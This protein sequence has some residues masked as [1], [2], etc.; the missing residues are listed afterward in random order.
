M[1]ARAL[2]AR[3]KFSLCLHAAIDVDGHE[4]IG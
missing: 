3:Q 4:V 1:I 2:Q